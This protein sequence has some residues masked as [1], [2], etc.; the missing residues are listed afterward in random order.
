[1]LPSSDREYT[2]ILSVKNVIN[3]KQINLKV[4]LPIVILWGYV[5]F[6]KL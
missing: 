6:V 4:N 1:M 2:E 5:G 3:I